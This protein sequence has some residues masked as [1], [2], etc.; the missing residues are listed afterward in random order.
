M[1]KND[2]LNQ[3]AQLKASIR[4]SKEFAQGVVRGTNGRF[5]FVVLD[6][7]REA[8]LPPEA[9][10]RVFPGDRVEVSL[11]EVTDG[12][13]EA[14]LEKLICTELKAFVGRYVV[15][16][17]GHFVQPDLPQFNRWIF[18]PPKNRGQAKEGDYLSCRITRHPFDCGGKA[19]AK[20]L[21][22]IGSNE[23]A[24]IEHSYIIAKFDLPQQWSEEELGEA[25]SIESG[26]A[27]LASSR[28]DLTSMPFVTIDAAST[29]DMDDA[30][31]VE[32]NDNGW[33]LYVAIADPGSL[34]NLD[35]H[36]EK[37]A[38]E[39]ANT[40]YLPGEAL[41]MLPPE[42]SHNSFSLVEGQDRPALVCKMSIRMDGEVTE[43]SFSEACIRSHQKLSYQGV[44]AHTL[45]QNSEVNPELADMITLLFQLAQARNSYRKE[46]ALLIEDRADYEFVLNEQGKI[47][48][49]E[50]R[51]R[52]NGH[53]IVEEAMLATNC[54]AG[55]LL[56][57]QGG[58]LLSSHKGIREERLK[59]ARTLISEC[60]PEIAEADITTLEG[61]RRA[62]RA[63]H[64][65]QQHAANLG[66]LKRMLRAG[67]LVNEPM[68]HLGL[69]LTHYATVTSPIRRYQDLHNHRVL[70]AIARKEATSP[71]PADSLES[72]KAQITKGRRACRQLEQWL[73]CQYMKDKVNQAFDGRVALVNNQG[74][75]VRLDENGV[76]G[77]VLMRTK[78]SQ[79]TFDQSRLKITL[80]E[81]SYQPDQPV[82]VKVT[83]VDMERR[84]VD[85]ELV[86]AQ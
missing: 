78:K 27:D 46:K 4:A 54:C 23:D 84:R 34:V 43:Y 41:T 69:G 42:L 38:R 73:V 28:E 52:N 26:L 8:F 58:G 68:P 70:K 83:G 22:R 82:R 12:K 32:A 64:L 31:Y 79:P 57:Q 80:G 66:A 63:M 55:E 74:I 30:L 49:V 19:Q 75:G 77:F 24:G 2:S 86:S 20:V 53:L 65:D 59:D 15:R 51:E 5:G 9:M 29:R 17:Q 10:Q 67:E 44:A 3:L 33:L 85:M 1:L 39:R 71:F 62:I 11:N 13:L 81:M 21:D 76:D 47:E 36:L 48:R 7:Q 16:G 35:S 40:V 6:D 37:A 50:K 14:E 45:K 56:A 61:Y 72:L 25:Q 18:L 60:V